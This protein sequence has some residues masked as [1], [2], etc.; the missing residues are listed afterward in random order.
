MSIPAV[1]S[2]KGAGVAT[3]QLLRLRWGAGA[4]DQAGAARSPLRPARRRVQRRRRP[5]IAEERVLAGDREDLVGGLLDDR[6]PGVVVLVH[7]VAEALEPAALARPSRSATKASTL[8]I[9]P[10]SVSILIT[11]SLAPPWRGP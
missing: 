1:Y 8:S 9:E 11:A 4:T 6:R 5:R 3:F 2:G 7:P 10:I